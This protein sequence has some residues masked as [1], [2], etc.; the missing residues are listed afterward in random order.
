MHSQMTESSFGEGSFQVMLIT[1]K[2][3]A[4]RVDG[5][6]LHTYE[7]RKPLMKCGF[8][9]GYYMLGSFWSTRIMRRIAMQPSLG[10]DGVSR[11]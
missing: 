4:T 9:D 2:N 8:D 10:G 5:E 7:K 6:R 3:W 1:G 11:A